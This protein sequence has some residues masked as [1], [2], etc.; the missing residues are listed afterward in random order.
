MHTFQFEKEVCFLLKQLQQ[1]VHV[2]LRERINI[3][4][5]VTRSVLEVCME[6]ICSLDLEK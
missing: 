1:R 3:R 5:G 6:I 4:E 2:N